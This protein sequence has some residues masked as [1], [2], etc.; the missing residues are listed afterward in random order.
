MAANK[1][2]SHSILVATTDEVH[3]TRLSAALKNAGFKVVHVFD[4]YEVVRYCQKQEE[5]GIMILDTSLPGL[6]GYETTRLIRESGNFEIMIILLAWF[7]VQ[8]L[9]MAYAVGANE[10]VAKPVNE[11][12]L[13]EMVMKLQN[14]EETK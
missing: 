7:S 9:E 5:T 4:G 11:E 14:S 6:N 12:E 10:L 8:A 1:L 3:L 2:P 13:V